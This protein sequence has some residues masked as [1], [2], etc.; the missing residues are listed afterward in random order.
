MEL[1]MWRE[2][3]CPYDLAVE[4]LKLKFVHIMNEYRTAGRYS[5]IEQV[6]GRVKSI[7]SILD[8]M[9]RKKININ[10][11]ETDLEDIA[12]IRVICQFVED[13]DRVVEIIEQ[14][15]DMEIKTKKDYITKAKDSG[16]RSFHVIIY[17]DPH[18][19]HEFL[20]NSGA[21]PSVQIQ[22]KYPRAYH[23]KAHECGGC[24]RGP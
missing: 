3:L 24:H 5:P 17:Y 14:R 23:G 11:I 20:G 12:G 7:S 19:G 22:G 15:S 4:E 8:K 21:L 13:I 16:Y 2:I 1:Q 6:D 18:T 10:E 9:Q